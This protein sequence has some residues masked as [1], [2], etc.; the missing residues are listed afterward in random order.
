M[1]NSSEI[2]IHQHSIFF[3]NSCP[4]DGSKDPVLESVASSEKCHPRYRRRVGQNH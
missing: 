2:G 1:E 4:G 3:I